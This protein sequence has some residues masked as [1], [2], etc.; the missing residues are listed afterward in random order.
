VCWPCRGPVGRGFNP[1]TKPHT[2]NRKIVY[3]TKSRLSPVPNATNQRYKRKS[4]SSGIIAGCPIHFAFS[5]AWWESSGP[6]GRGPAR[7]GEFNPDTKPHTINR[8]LVYATK[9]RISWPTSLCHANAHFDRRALIAKKT[10][11]RELGGIMCQCQWPAVM[12]IVRV[13]QARNPSTAAFA[14]NKVARI[15]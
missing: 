11:N 12:T 8:K 3:A 7:R 1:D 2:I 6:V 13:A 15:G 5:A 14:W 4:P 9:S 10:K